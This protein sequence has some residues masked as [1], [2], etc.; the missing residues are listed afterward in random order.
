MTV[1]LAGHET[2][3]SSMSWA[4]L[5]LARAPEV[6]DQ[7]RRELLAFPSE[8]PNAEELQALPCLDKV[9]KEVLRLHAPVFTTLKAATKDSIIPLARPV[10]DKNGNKCHELL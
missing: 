6:Q 4:L 10:V 1:I 3:S 9:A 7:L 5:A 2:I 8:S